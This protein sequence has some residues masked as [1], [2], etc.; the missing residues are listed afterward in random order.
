MNPFPLVHPLPR[1]R[2]PACREAVGES[3]DSV[4]FVA[5]IVGK[6]SLWRWASNCWRLG[7][8]T[9]EEESNP[10]RGSSNSDSLSRRCRSSIPVSGS[11]G[12]DCR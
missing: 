11:L 5:R 8:N 4:A 7:A 3:Q 10:R 1:C 6:I 12:P 2:V 9:Q